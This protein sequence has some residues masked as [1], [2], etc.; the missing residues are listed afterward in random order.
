MWAEVTSN[1]SIARVARAA[2]LSQWEARCKSSNF[3]SFHEAAELYK[4]EGSVR[5]GLNGN[6]EG[7][8]E[9]ASQL[10]SF[11]LSCLNEFGVEPD[12]LRE[13]IRTLKVEW[14]DEQE[15]IGVSKWWIL[16]IGKMWDDLSND[17]SISNVNALLAGCW[18]SSASS[19]FERMQL[20]RKSIYAVSG[21]GF[22]LQEALMM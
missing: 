10:F 21:A 12:N 1:A 11:Y 14:I 13:T 17:L 15:R 9:S 3:D 18:I 16:T 2:A 8:V 20:V 7:L 22:L 4:C 6:D 19:V 5:A